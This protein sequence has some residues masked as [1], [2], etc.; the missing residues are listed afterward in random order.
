MRESYML[1]VNRGGSIGVE[2]T[3]TNAHTQGVGMEEGPQ[4]DTID[5]AIGCSN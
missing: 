2:V 4:A 1:A 3:G 5:P